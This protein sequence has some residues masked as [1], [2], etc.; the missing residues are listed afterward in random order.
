MTIIISFASKE[1]R[2]I[3]NSVSGNIVKSK[4]RN[5]RLIIT[6]TTKVL[7]MDFYYLIT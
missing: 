3:F 2:Y 4:N 7:H 6:Q 1:V 5:L